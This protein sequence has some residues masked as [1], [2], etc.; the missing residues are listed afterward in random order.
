M[1][2]WIKICGLTTREAV[3]AAVAARV[4]AVGFV[5]APSR[6]RVTAQR[7]VELAREVPATIMRVAVMLH[8]EQALLDEVWNVFRPDILQSDVEDFARLQVPPELQALPVMRA[9]STAP[10]PLPPRVLFEGA[11]SGAGTVAD[12]AHAARVARQTQVVLAGGLTP[13][14]VAAAIA[15]VDPFGV[16]VSSGVEREPGIKDPEK[17]RAFVA[18]ARAAAQERSH[19]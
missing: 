17:I 14:N 4:N 2:L 7:A 10:L 12:W 5:F 6:R 11:V 3:D 8:P 9:G 15:T 19:V 13:L 1:P 18:A 16:D